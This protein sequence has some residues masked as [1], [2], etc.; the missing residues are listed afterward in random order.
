MLRNFIGFHPAIHD[1]GEGDPP[2]F[3]QVPK[4]HH[5]YLRILPEVEIERL[6]NAQKSPLV[7]VK[8]LHD[9]Q[10]AAELLQHFHRSK[11]LWIFRHYREVILSHLSYYKGRY[12]PLT[13][14]KDLLELNAHSWKAEGLNEGMRDFIMQH[15]IQATTPTAAFALFWLARNS[16]LLHQKHPNLLVVNYADLIA[17]PQRALMMISQHIQMDL[18]PRYALFPQ[19]RERPQL[20]PNSIPESILAACEAMHTKLCAMSSN[21]SSQSNS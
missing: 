2:Y 11:G 13:Y 7:L 9:S 18:D 5:R 15:R 8:P 19:R 10:R 1:H 21:L 6:T 20:L 16:L 3:W 14:L 12:D 17:D 4:E